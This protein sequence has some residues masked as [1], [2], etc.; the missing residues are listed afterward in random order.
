MTTNLPAVRKILFVAT[1]TPRDGE[2]LWPRPFST[3]GHRLSLLVREAV[4]WEAEE[5]IARTE[6]VN[7]VNTPAC[8]FKAAKARLPEIRAMAEGR[9]CIAVGVPAAVLLGAPHGDDWWFMWDGSLAAMPHPSPLNRWWNEPG[10]PAKA[11][12]FLREALT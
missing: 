6:R 12:Q 5:Y 1:N 2:A 11:V 8:D 3:A 9:R 10:N 4:G 7:F